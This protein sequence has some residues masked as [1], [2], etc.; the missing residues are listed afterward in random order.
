MVHSWWTWSISKNLRWIPLLGRL[1][2]EQEL[3]LETLPSVCMMPGDAQLLMAPVPKWASEVDNFAV[4][5][6]DY[7][8]AKS[9]YYQDMLPSV[10]WVQPHVNGVPRS[11]IFVKLKLY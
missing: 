3:Y 8:L 2:L 7:T 1:L 10:D 4:H 11:T 5:F 6:V 9:V